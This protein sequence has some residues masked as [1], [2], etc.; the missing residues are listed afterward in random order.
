V[1]AEQSFGLLGGHSPSV[2][3]GARALPRAAVCRDSPSTKA[4]SVSAEQPAPSV[5]ARAPLWVLRVAW[6][7]PDADHGFGPAGL[8]WRDGR[9]EGWWP[10]GAALDQVCRTAEGVI[11]LHACLLVHAP[12]NAHAHL[13]LTGLAGQLAPGQDFGAWVQGVL[14]W[15]QAR[16]LPGLVEDWCRGRRLA[17][18]GGACAVADIDSVGAAWKVAAP[19]PAG[20]LVLPHVELL[21]ARDP[22]RLLGQQARLQELINAPPLAPLGI[23]PH[24]PQTVSGPLLAAAGRA[25]QQAGWRVQIH[26]AE[27]E[28]ELDWWQGRES[29]MSKWAGP[30]P[31]RRPDGQFH[32]YL[33]H[34]ESA[35][36][37]GPRLALIHGNFPQA[38]EP[39]RLAASGTTLVHCPGSHRFFGRAAF[40]LRRY[41]EAGVRLAIGTDSLASNASLDM[42]REMTLLHAEFPWLSPRTT[43]RMASEHAAPLV[44]G[45]AGTG[46]LEPGA[47]AHLL[48]VEVNARSPEEA[49][50]AWVCGQ[51]GRRRLWVC[52]SEALATAP[53]RA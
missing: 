36:L 44:A 13:E 42:Q 38:G 27:T 19:L 48:A 30:G 40:P 28:A 47:P 22:G 7:W 50:A 20:T 52:G 6:L 25:A 35:G 41:L 12:I 17:E 23:S 18:L 4:P 24:A 10:A 16:T 11:D 5:P 9:I 32:S 33:D 49:L 1:P 53:V 3:A 34:L 29:P 43:W 51:T 21:D 45:L 2:G 15:R 46:R 31:G 37:L 26:W 14:A 8:A 39:E